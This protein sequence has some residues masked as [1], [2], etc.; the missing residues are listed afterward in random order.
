MFSDYFYFLTLR[1]TV[2][3][4]RMKPFVKLV[5]PSF[6]PLHIV[7]LS[8]IEMKIALRLFIYKFDLIEIKDDESRSN[9]AEITAGKRC[10]DKIQDE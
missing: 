10:I 1:H 6:L 3:I 4:N 7:F 5:S 2:Y 9:L 8:S